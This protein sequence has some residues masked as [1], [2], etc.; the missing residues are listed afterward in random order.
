MWRQLGNVGWSYEDV[1]PYFK[2]SEDQERGA[3]E[4]SRRRRPARRVR[5]QAAAERRCARPSSTRAR[6]PASRKQ[7]RLQRRQ[8]GGR[9]LFQLTNR[10]GR[11]CSAAVA[12]LRPARGAAQPAASSLTRSCT[13][14]ELGGKRATG[15]R[16]ATRWPRGD[17]ARR[18]RGDPG[19]GCHRLAADPAAL[20]HRSGRR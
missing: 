14:C 6:R 7:Q 8:P 4:L 19:G 11:R 16:F 17:C 13:A 2:R 3:D 5:R 9:R 1:L 15:V 20:R 10:N 12:Y 18:A